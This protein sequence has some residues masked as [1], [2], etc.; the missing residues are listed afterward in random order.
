MA[1]KTTLGQVLSQTVEKRSIWLLK[2]THTYLYPALSQKALLTASATGCLWTTRPGCTMEVA[3]SNLHVPGG[4]HR[5]TPCSAGPAGEQCTGR[6]GLWPAT[7]HQPCPPGSVLGGFGDAAGISCSTFPLAGCDPYT[8]KCYLLLELRLIDLSPYPSTCPCPCLSLSLSGSCFET[9]S[10]GVAQVGPNQA[11]PI[12]ASRVLMWQ[13]C[14]TTHGCF[15]G[16]CFTM[17]F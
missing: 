1:L 7:S 5:W 4:L 15:I 12:S 10:H 3:C 11:L 2:T 16:P 6:K 14:V 8:R 9:G 13:V 17:E